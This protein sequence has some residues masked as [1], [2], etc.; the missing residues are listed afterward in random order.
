MAKKVEPLTIRRLL[1]SCCCEAS[2][3]KCQGLLRQLSKR[4][5]NTD[6]QVLYHM[7]ETY[8]EMGPSRIIYTD[9]LAGLASFLVVA[10]GGTVIGIVWGFATGFV[11]RFT[12]QVRVIEPIFIFVMAYLAYLSAEIFHLSGILA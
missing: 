1:V 6:T 8:S 2:E 4:P 9:V 7:F 11:T 3:G 5:F 10:I 12:H